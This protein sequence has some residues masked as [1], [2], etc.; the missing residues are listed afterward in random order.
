MPHSFVT[1]LVYELPVGKGRKWASNMPGA[2]EQILGGWQVSSIV[3]LNSGFPVY[4]VVT[5]GNALGAYGFGYSPAQ[6]VGDPKV[7]ERTTDRWFN[8]DAFTEP[9]PYTIGNAPRHDSNMREEGAKNVDFALAKNFKAEAFRVQFRAEF[10]NMFNTPQF[11]GGDQF[12]HNIRT[13]VTCGDF[14]QVFGVRNLP[15]NIQ[16]GLKVDF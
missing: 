2:A 12:S 8:T 15:R 3:R 11:G 1:A 6:V 13:C 14:G 9:A 5:E 10:L 4:P 16:F 7:N